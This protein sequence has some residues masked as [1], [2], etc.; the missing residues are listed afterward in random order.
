MLQ[1]DI[2]LLKSHILFKVGIQI[3][4]QPNALSIEI[5]YKI[6]LASMIDR[7]IS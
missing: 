3:I 6:K 7:K 4:I 2:L 5:V 1:F